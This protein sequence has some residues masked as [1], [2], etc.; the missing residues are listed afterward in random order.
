M[1]VTFTGVK[2]PSTSSSSTDEYSE[3]RVLSKVTLATGRFNKNKCESAGSVFVKYFVISAFLKKMQG[4]S[5]SWTIA[6]WGTDGILLLQ[7]RHEKSQSKQQHNTSSVQNWTVPTTDPAPN[8]PHFFSRGDV[9][10]QPG[11]LVVT[12]REVRGLR[13][14]QRHTGPRYRVPLVRREPVPQHRLHPVS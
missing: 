4:Y 6:R 11:P 10:V 13:T 9:L 8:C 2:I 5:K 12:R 1:N 3:S 14:V 7:W